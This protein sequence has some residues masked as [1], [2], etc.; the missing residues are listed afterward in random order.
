MLT[1][2]R[3]WIP[4]FAVSA[5][6]DIDLMKY[7]I[8]TNTMIELEESRKW[9]VLG[10]KGTGKTAL[11]QY[12][13]SDM[14]QKRNTLSVGLNFKDYPWPIHQ[15]YKESMEGEITAYYK[16]WEYIIVVKLLTRLIEYCES[17]NEELN[18]ELK[19]AKKLIYEIYGRP[20]PTILEII[21][22]KLW[23]FERLSL[24]ALE[25]GELNFNIGELSFDEVSQ[26]RALIANLKSNAFALLNYFEKVLTDNIGDKKITMVLDQLDENWLADQL[27]E[28]SKILINLIN[29]C[30][31]INNDPKF[32][33]QV[34]VIIFLRSDIF[35]TLRFNDKNKIYQSSAVEIRWDAESLDIMFYERIKRCSTGIVELDTNIG[36]NCIF[37][38]RTVRHGAPPF[39]HILRRT[40]YRPR[41]IVVYFNKIR[42]VHRGSA[43]GLYISK[44]IYNAERDFSISM[45]NELI[46]E[47][48]NQKP[49]IE[50]Y[51][52]VLQNIGFQTFEYYEFYEAFA[53]VVEKNDKASVNEALNFLFTNSIV[54]QKI[55]LNWEYICTNQY[56][57]IDYEKSFHV[58]NGLKGR[59]TLTETRT[60]RI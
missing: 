58:N 42:A 52:N 41:D 46:D 16:S 15:L 34:R 48:G 47:W 44:D 2:I 39:R 8:S 49:E 40:F 26:D 45:Y 13:L 43:S 51:L 10:R 50:K 35:D 60:T 18:K 12:Y 20:N 30:K 56:M 17:V 55:S 19:N 25:A 5:E 28:Y 29:V 1:P 27:D 14:Y 6:E 3:D 31:S 9:M 33:S 57:Q 21:K 22:G 23:R 59:L 24:P 32:R 53:K 7:F 11:Y 54:G 37:E 4:E 36:S 38:N